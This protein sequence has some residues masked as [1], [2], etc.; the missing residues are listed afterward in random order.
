MMRNKLLAATEEKIE[1]NLFGRNRQDYLKAVNAGMKAALHGGTNSILAK[2]KDSKNPIH[3]SVVGAI[4][5]SLI[6]RHQ[7][8]NTMP[9]K[10]MIPAATS[11]M[12]HALDFAESLGM[13]QIDKPELDE[14]THLLVNTLLKRLGITPN[15]LHTAA[16]KVHALM[17]NP[18]AMERMKYQI[19]M[20]KSPNSPVATPIPGE[21]EDGKAA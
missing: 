17:E 2:L 15:M 18:V 19:G 9:M 3:D 16:G 11:L 20:T 4:N 1:S 8:R 12:L 21:D 7:S 14:A 10:A 5:L 6:L 13:V